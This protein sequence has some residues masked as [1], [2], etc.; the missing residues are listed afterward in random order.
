[1]CEGCVDTTISVHMCEGCVD[2]T[3]RVHMCVKAV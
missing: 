2:T 1:M 3:I